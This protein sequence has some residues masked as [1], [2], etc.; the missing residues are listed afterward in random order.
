MEKLSPDCGLAIRGLAVAVILSLV[1]ESCFFGAR[2]VRLEIVLSCIPQ[3]ATK[4]NT[5]FDEYPS[6]IC[7]A[8]LFYKHFITA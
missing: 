7:N 3:F 6:I 5:G 8:S 1:F 4:A 2:M